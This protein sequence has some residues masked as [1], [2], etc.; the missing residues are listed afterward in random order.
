MVVEVVAIHMHPHSS[1]KEN[2]FF[3]YIIFLYKV[4]MYLN[5]IF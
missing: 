1:Y 5:K 2:T 4:H 3:R